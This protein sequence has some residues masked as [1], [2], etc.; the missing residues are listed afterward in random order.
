[1]IA[2]AYSNRPAILRLN[3][4]DAQTV[5]WPTDDG[6][7]RNRDGLMWVS[8]PDYGGDP[9]FGAAFYVLDEDSELDCESAL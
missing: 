5:C 6:L 4:F 7:R 9:E 2:Y 3:A 1:M 8:A